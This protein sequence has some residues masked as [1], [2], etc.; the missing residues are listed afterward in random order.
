MTLDIHSLWTDKSVKWIIRFFSALFLILIGFKIYSLLTFND[1][2]HQP[3]SSISPKIITKNTS[4]DKIINSS[5]F[6]D[7]VP[8][9]LTTAEIKQSMLNVDIAGV[10]FAD[11]VGNSQVIIRGA[12]GDEHNYRVGDT[13]PGGAVIK[14]IM[15][16]GILVDYNN[17]LERL[18]LQKNKLT[19]EPPAQPLFKD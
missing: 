16:D 17:A 3:V 10:L 7:Y 12:G 13:I 9:D 8:T 2:V 6:G 19:F 14:R 1:R 15:V 5:L 4:E 18:N 11:N